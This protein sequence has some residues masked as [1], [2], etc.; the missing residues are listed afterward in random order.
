MATDDGEE[1]PLIDVDIM[2]LIPEEDFVTMN[3][4]VE[5]PEGEMITFGCSEPAWASPYF[6]DDYEYYFD[7]VDFLIVDEV[8][9]TQSANQ[10]AKQRHRLR[11]DRRRMEQE[12]IIDAM[13]SFSGGG[14]NGSES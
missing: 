1:L 9:S 6:V 10:A 3:V 13:D 14:T 4:V 12:P 2:Y 5:F 7:E 11:G 8:G